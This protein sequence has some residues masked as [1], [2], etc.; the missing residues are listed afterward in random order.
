MHKLS[1]KVF[2]SEPHKSGLSKRVFVWLCAVAPSSSSSDPG[3]AAAPRRVARLHTLRKPW[4]EARA[5]RRRQH[6]SLSCC[7]RTRGALCRSSTRRRVPDGS[8]RPRW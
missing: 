8:P 3:P 7:R 1:R 2:R 4:A 6:A 5:G